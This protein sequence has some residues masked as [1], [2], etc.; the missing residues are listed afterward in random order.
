[1]EAGN[2]GAFDAGGDSIGLNIKLPHEQSLNRYVT[3]TETFH[4]FF[5]RKVSLSFASEVYIYFPGGFGT[6]DEFFELVTLVQTN[7]IEPV[8]IVL[9][10]KDF[11]VPLLDV[12]RTTLLEQYQT[13]SPE[14]VHLYKVVDSAEEAIELIKELIPLESHETDDRED[15][16]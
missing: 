14:D 2:R 5:S 1:M 15:K 10:G 12:M 13:I 3:D 16:V 4:Y 8:P 9:V 7:K 11:W 6:L